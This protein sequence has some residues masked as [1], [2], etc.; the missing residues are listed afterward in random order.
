MAQQDEG[1]VNGIR[2]SKVEEIDEN[3]DTGLV[4]VK[5]T[6]LLYHNISLKPYYTYSGTEQSKNIQL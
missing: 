1:K 5:H 2:R 6:P 4:R 3:S